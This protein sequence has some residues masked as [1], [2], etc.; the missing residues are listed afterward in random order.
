MKR[1]N[2]RVCTLFLAIVAILLPA[3]AL[4][5][6]T[7]DTTEAAEPQAEGSSEQPA[8]EP[9]EQPDAGSETDAPTD[10]F[11]AGVDVPDGEPI[12]LDEAIDRTR[13][14]N[15]TWAITEERITQSR[16]AR[17]EARA[18]LL[19]RLVADGGV[20]AYGR[21]IEFN[22]NVVQPR[23]DWRVSGSASIVIFDGTKYPMVSRAGELLEA[24]KAQSKWQRET[25]VFETTSAYYVLAAAQEQVAI[26]AKTVE[27]RERELERAQ[28]LLD[29]GIAVKLDV[30]RARTNMLDAKQSLVDAKA[31]LGNA[32]DSFAVILGEQPGAN[33][34]AAIGA[35]T[36]T[37][38]PAEVDV[39]LERR[40]D[41][42]STLRQIEATKLEEQ[43]VWWSLF[44]TVG[45]SA[46][47][48]VGPPTT[49][50]RPDGYRL[51]LTLS[52][53]WV[54]YDGGARYAR[55]DQVESRVREQQLEYERSLRQANAGVSRA[56]RNWSS[57]VSAVE[58]AREQVEAAQETYDNARARF[59]NGLANSLEVIDASQQ[60]FQSKVLLN[61]R[62]LDARTAA[63]EFDYLRT[64]TGQDN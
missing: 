49:F 8:E 61:Q 59:E 26:A 13:S 42:K 48:V 22:D 32:R 38:P 64:L 51:S 40:A 9:A 10:E 12:S 24:T 16:A 29:A 30:T 55:L 58:V 39:E 45:L 5:Q 57:A 23:F 37:N 6:D 62:I 2:L 34:S 47:G 15:E 35:E 28:A 20:T 3:T 1:Q 25:I 17:R 60:L 27:L 4:A 56:R 41:F 53:T 33:Y 46:N 11:S 36:V 31:R 52:A 44:P 50:G 63:A 7:S 43:S 21:E 14:E 18:E 54:L 19:P